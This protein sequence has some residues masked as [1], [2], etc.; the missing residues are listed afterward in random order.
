MKKHSVV[1][2]L[3][4]MTLLVGQTSLFLT[5]AAAD[6]DPFE[7]GEHFYD[8]RGSEPAGYGGTRYFTVSSCAYASYA[9]KHYYI[10]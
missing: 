8:Y 9:H 7:V 6:Y 2:M 4:V 5:S 3:L 1:A 10:T